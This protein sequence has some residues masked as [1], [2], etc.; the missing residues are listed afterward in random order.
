MDIAEVFIQSAPEGE[1]QSSWHKRE[2]RIQLLLE[3]EPFQIKLFIQSGMNNNG[4]HV[5][6]SDSQTSIIYLHTYLLDAE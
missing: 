4:H 6:L 1:F 3:R 5:D 2:V